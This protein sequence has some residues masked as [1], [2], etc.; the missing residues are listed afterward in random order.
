VW[1]LAGAMLTLQTVRHTIDYTFTAVKELRETSLERLP[2]D[3]VSGAEVDRAGTSRAVRGSER[4]NERPAVKWAKRVAHTGIGERWLVLSL[5]AALGAPRAALVALLALGLL[6]LAYTSAGRILRARAWRGAPPVPA[7]EQEIVAAQLDLGPLAT[8][9]G[10]SRVVP[11][12]RFAW[13]LPPGL[14]LAEYAVVLALVAVVSPESAV[15][16]FVLLFAVAYH[17][18]DELYAVLNRLSPL[19]D[20]ARLAGLG[21]DGRVVVVLVLCL[22]DAAALHVGLWLLAALLA[23]L[24][25]GYGVARAAREASVRA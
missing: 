23:V 16:A 11:A 6:S 20:V 15:A 25:L 22:F 12:A 19:P 24:F 2:L 9:V 4:S 14:R 13:S 17:H 18:Y 21:A 5:G 10:R 8:P 7:R 1:L 3:Q